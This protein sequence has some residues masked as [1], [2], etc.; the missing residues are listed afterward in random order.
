MKK[1]LALFVASVVFSA[2][3]FAADLTVDAKFDLT[4]KDPAGSYLTFKSAIVSLEK[5]QVDVVTGAS[6]AEGTDK[7]N[8]LRPDVKG[9]ST[10]PGGFQSLVKYG[11]SPEQTYKE[12]VPSAWKNADGSITIQYTH[13]GSAYKLTTDKDGKFQFPVG[14]FLVRK[15]GY[16]DAKAGVILHPDFSKDG[17]TATI[18]WTAVWDDKIADGKV[19]NNQAAQKTGKITADKGASTI[20]LWTGALQVTL[21]GTVV[22]VKG[23]LNAELVK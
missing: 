6:K 10:F 11:V 3:A 4:G 2:G 22:T 16:V 23:E 12:D 9:K 19:I 20:Y 13:R 14:N 7:W 15:I 21:D 1:I 8:Y 18:N 5:D 17:T